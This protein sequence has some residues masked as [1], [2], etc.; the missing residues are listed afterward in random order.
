MSAPVIRMR[1]ELYYKNYVA[2]F[3]RIKPG[4]INVRAATY[5]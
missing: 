4:G 1:V 2:P 3:V 5:K